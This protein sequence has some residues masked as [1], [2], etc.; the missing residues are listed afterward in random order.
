M[1]PLADASTKSA[2]LSRYHHQVLCFLFLLGASAIYLVAFSRVGVRGSYYIAIHI[3]LS[4]LMF[5]ALFTSREDIPKTHAWTL[6]TGLLARII[7]V[8]VPAFTSSDAQRYLWDGFTALAGLDPYRVTP[9]AAL[10]QIAGRWP[11]PTNS[12]SYVTIYPPGALALYTL[13]AAIGSTRAFWIWKILV[14]AASASTLLIARELLHARRSERYLPLVAFS[15]LLLLESGVGAH[16]DVFSGLCVAAALLAIERRALLSSGIILGVGGLIKFVPLAAVIPLALSGRRKALKLV[17]AAVVVMISGYGAALA[18]GLHP[19]GSLIVFFQKWR[20]GA[21]LYSAASFLFTRSLS[22][23]VAFLA[24]LAIFIVAI[25][26]GQASRLVWFLALPLLTS[27]VVFPWY[28]T[29]VV[30]AAAVYPSPFMILW[31]TT[32]PLTYEVIDRF[33]ATGVWRTATWPLWIVAIGWGIAVL[34]H[35]KN[36][37]KT[38]LPIALPLF[39]NPAPPS[40][41]GQDFLR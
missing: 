10:A 38:R 2:Q 36:R 4:A 11:E 23:L 37:F 15:P 31:A 9:D 32:M 13:S 1:T 28:L 17:I 20:F 6:A 12:A 24:A 22:R 27:P 25:E 39:P 33:D 16:V 19:L 7:L 8:G 41:T 3:F 40:E 14:T 18:F 5:G 30:V 26:K 35:S 34:I 29:P 21:P